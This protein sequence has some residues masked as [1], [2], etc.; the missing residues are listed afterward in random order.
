MEIVGQL[1]GDCGNIEWRLWDEYKD[2][3]VGVIALVKRRAVRV[4]TLALDG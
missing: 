4:V 3:I 2:W 1:N